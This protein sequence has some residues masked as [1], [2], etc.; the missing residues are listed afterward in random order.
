MSI[1]ITEY[2]KLTK[3]RSKYRNVRSGGFDSKLEGRCAAWLRF[4]QLAGDVRWYIRQTRFDLEGGVVYRA[5]FLAVTAAGTIDV[6]DAT[7]CMTP[8]KVNKL[9][10]V[11]ARYG[12]D[13]ILWRGE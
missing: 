1:T 11:K 6:I 9:K 12:I 7:G 8:S 3:K 5:D 2:R 10:Q 4:R 13:V